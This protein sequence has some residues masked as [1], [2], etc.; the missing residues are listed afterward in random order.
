MMID[1]SPLRVVGCLRVVL[2][3]S[4]FTPRLVRILIPPI[5][6]VNI[7]TCPRNM[8]PV[9]FLNLASLFSLSCLR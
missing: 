1:P 3:V 9:A 8:L 7:V 6:S 4:C 5:I 2:P